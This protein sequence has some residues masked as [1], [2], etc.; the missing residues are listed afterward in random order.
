MAAARGQWVLLLVALALAVPARAEPPPRATVAFVTERPEIDGALDDP[1][2]R[3]AT[4]VDDFTQVEPAEGAPPTFRT[5]VRFVS[6]TD[7]LFI[8]FRAYDPDPGAIVANLMARD[9]FLFFDDNFTLILDTFH[10]RRN[11]YFFQVNPNGGRRDATFTPQRFEENWDGIWYAKARI[12]DEG[13]TAEIEIPFKT[14]SFRSGS[15]VWG[16]NMTRRV[17][18]LNEDDRWADPVIQ[19]M[20]INVGQ[21]GEL[22]GLAHADQGIGLDVVPAAAVRRIDDSDGDIHETKFEPSLDAFYRLLPSLTASLTANT[23]FAET[24]VDERQVNLT[25]FALFFPEKRDFFLQDSGIF[26]FGGLRNENGIPFFSRRIG[27]DAA[28]E[29]VRLPVGGKISGRVGRFNIGAL[30]IQQDSHANVDSQNIVVGRVSAN[31]LAESTM[32]ILVT[33]GDPLT[34]VDN[35]LVGADFN[36]RSTTLFKNK[37]VT[38]N[39]WTQYS[40]TS[41]TEDQQGAWGGQLSY[42]N[43]IV[44]WRLKFKEIQEN[45]NPALGFVNRPGI[46]QYDGNWRYRIR[47]QHSIFRTIDQKIAGSLVTDRNDVVQTANLFYTPVELA[48]QIDDVFNIQLAHLFDRIDEPFFVVPGYGIPEGSYH[49][50]SAITTIR[51]SRNRKLRVYT[52]IGVGGFYNGWGIRVNPKLEWRPSAHWLLAAELD[53]RRFYDMEGY[54][55]LPN[56]SIGPIRSFDFVRRLIRVR[57]NINFTPDLSWKTFAQYDNASDSISIQSRLHWIIVEG[58]EIFLVLGQDVDTAD[59][60]FR[61]GRTEPVAKIGWTLRF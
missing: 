1:V 23:D 31:V 10:D 27:L 44:H 52:T 35:S 12:D 6:D 11:G 26:N 32:G 17:R 7:S 46:R 5:E 37:T 55:V 45:F 49:F 14:L 33:H 30:D 9:E 13:W 53:E 18:R 29:P 58:R 51:T 57:I 8:A 36:Y 54:E 38:A 3:Q 43:D 60:D 39:A 25:R 15:N 2:W 59:G 24:E 42:P 48:T 61:A 41:G 4:V 22:V 21:A 56:G 40:S 19:R 16:L 50:T 34:N 47:P 28:G 20:L